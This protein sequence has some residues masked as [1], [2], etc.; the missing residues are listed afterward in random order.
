ML[1]DEKDPS[2]RR[3]DERRRALDRWRVKYAPPARQWLKLAHKLSGSWETV[4]RDFQLRS[5]GT[6]RRV[7]LGEAEIP[8]HVIERYATLR[9]Y[10]AAARALGRLEIRAALDRA[11]A[12]TPRTIAIYTNRGKQVKQ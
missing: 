10:R 6:A 12:E 7:A 2:V 9:A 5:K 11:A 1:E 8:D 3:T 4:A